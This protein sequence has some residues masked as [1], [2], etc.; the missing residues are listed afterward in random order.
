MDNR[1]A[2]YLF[3][4]CAA[5]AFELWYLAGAVNFLPAP[6]LGF[7]ET[8]MKLA[9]SAWTL[10]LATAVAIYAYAGRLPRKQ[11]SS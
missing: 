9:A 11:P 2:V 8:H 6:E 4:T 1:F 10:T 3:L 5:G 7:N